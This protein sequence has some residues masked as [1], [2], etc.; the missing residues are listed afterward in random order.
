MDPNEALREEADIRRDERER[1]AKLVEQYGK[2]LPPGIERG[3]TLLVVN[4]IRR[5]RLL[6]NKES[7]ENL[8]AAIKDEPVP[9]PAPTTAV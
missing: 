6:T 2:T 4:Q 3:V 5:G 9:H 8:I 7:M 1:C